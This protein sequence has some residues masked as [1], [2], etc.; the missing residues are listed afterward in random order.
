MS[1]KVL[2]VD[3]APFIREIL[4]S[5]LEG[6][7]E[8]VEV[9]EAVDGEEAIA[10]FESF[11]PDVIFMDIVMPKL[12]GIEATKKIRTK[13]SKTPIIG[14]STLDHGDVINRMISAGANTFVRK[15]FSL[16][17]LDAALKECL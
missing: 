6:K 14:L 16:E 7:P 15:P 8:F 1:Y 11:Q 4:Q 3:D 10:L 17:D 2:I 9:Q 13:N 5:Y 12:S